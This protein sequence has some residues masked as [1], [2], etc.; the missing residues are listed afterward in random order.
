[1]KEFNVMQLAEGNGKV[2]TYYV[3]N[4]VEPQFVNEAVYA[5][6][7]VVAQAV[8]DRSTCH[9]SGE[10]TASELAG[11]YNKWFDAITPL[12]KDN[13][14]LEVCIKVGDYQCAFHTYDVFKMMAEWEGLL[15]LSVKQQHR[16]CCEAEEQ[17]KG[18]EL[19]TYKRH[20]VYHPKRVTCAMEERRIADKLAVLGT[21]AQALTSEGMR[22]ALSVLCA[23]ESVKKLYDREWYAIA[24]DLIRRWY[25]RAYRKEGALGSVCPVFTAKDFEHGPE[26][27]KQVDEGYAKELLA[28]WRQF[29]AENAAPTWMKVGDFVQLKN[30]ELAPKKWQGKLK[31][32]QVFGQLDLY[33]DKLVWYAEVCT[34]SGRWDSVN[35]DVSHFDVWVE[36]EK[37]KR[38]KSEKGKVKS[39]KCESHGNHGKTQ[40]VS[41][42]NDRTETPQMTEQKVSAISAVSAGQEMSVADKLRAALRARLAA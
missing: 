13:M 25:W 16:F 8:L 26:L 33:K 5:V 4:E 17:P 28:Q 9:L 32:C 41:A 36:P 19:V 12:T 18:M 40:K 15:G 31:V 6:F 42:G 39:E 14:P 22:K 21:M 35:R 11:S 2:A 29:V 34:T 23:I 37:P 27:W 38:K 1:M 20:L 24:K 3:A 7:C 30:Q 10:R